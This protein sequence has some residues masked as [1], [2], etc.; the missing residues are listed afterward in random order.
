MQQ[1]LSYLVAVLAAGKNGL[2]Y[3]IPLGLG[4]VHI[5]GFVGLHLQLFDLFFELQARSIRNTHP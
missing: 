1:G 4:E 2:H 3:F 5:R